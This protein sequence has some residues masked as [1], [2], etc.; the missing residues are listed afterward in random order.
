MRRWGSMHRHSNRASERSAV[1]RGITAAYVAARGRLS[2]RGGRS[3]GAGSLQAA[4]AGRMPRT[5][6]NALKT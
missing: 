6:S 1:G 3:G 2:V 5:S 4:R